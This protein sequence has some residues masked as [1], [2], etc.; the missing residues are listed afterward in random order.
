M[1]LA[2]R[3]R[4]SSFEH[5]TT[6]AFARAMTEDLPALEAAQQVTLER[7]AEA[8]VLWRKLVQGTS[9][10]YLYADNYAGLFRNTKT[11]AGVEI[12]LYN[13]HV[14]P[15][16]ASGRCRLNATGIPYDEELARKHVTAFAEYCS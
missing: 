14:Y 10:E 4:G 3:A 6:R 16:F 11:R 13:Q 12:A 15:V 2:V 7:L 1:N 9:L 8:E 5:V